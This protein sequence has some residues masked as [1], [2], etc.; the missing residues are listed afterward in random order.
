MYF[1]FGGDESRGHLEEEMENFSRIMGIFRTI[2]SIIL[3]LLQIDDVE[4]IEEEELMK[5]IE[6]EFQTRSDE[7]NLTSTQRIYNFELYITNDPLTIYYIEREDMKK[8][9]VTGL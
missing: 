3:R 1:S 4:R 8:M 5:M 6:S 7:E 9:L 2:I